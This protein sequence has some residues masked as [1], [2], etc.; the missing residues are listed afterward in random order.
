MMKKRKYDELS[1]KL[2]PIANE[3]G[4]D[5]A[6]SF[7]ENYIAEHPD[8]FEGYLVRGEMHELMGEF[9]QALDGIAQQVLT[10]K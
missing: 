6:A 3:S 1:K 10:H 5:A 9:Q 4:M 8:S 7:L 2:V